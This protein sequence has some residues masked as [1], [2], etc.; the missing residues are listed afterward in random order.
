MISILFVC[1]GNICRSPMAEFIMKDICQKNNFD[2]CYIESAATSREAIGMNIHYSTREILNKYNIP[3]KRRQARQMTISDYDKFDYI[4]VMD[5]LNI[6]N[7][8]RIV[9]I[10]RE[11]KIHKLLDFSS[12]PRDIADPWYTDDFETTYKE[13]LE[14]CIG[15]FK[16]ISKN[17]G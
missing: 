2:N 14:G 16:E 3:Y 1:H 6:R 13:I 5:S 10:D 9:P 12:N 15:L 7:I 17:N 4:I 11:N 8:S